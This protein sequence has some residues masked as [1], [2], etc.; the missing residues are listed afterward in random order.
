[1]DSSA[2][3][4]RRDSPGLTATRVSTLII[5]FF[6]FVIFVAFSSA[7]FL[8]VGFYFQC[9]PFLFIILASVFILCFFVN[10]TEGL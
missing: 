1:M 4:V 10:L 7:T 5:F 9:F 6:Y 8:F 3:S 2:A